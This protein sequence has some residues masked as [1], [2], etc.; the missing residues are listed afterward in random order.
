MAHR[1]SVILRHIVLWHHT[2][3]SQA[4]LLKGGCPL[5]LSFAHLLFLSS[6]ILYRSTALRVSLSR[7][8]NKCDGHW[9]YQ[10]CVQLRWEHRIVIG[11][12]LVDS[13]LMVITTQNSPPPPLSRHRSDIFSGAVHI[14]L[15]YEALTIFHT[16]G[17]VVGVGVE[18]MVLKFG[19]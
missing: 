16:A 15:P 8:N 14:K 13:L 2:I 10:Q 18:I 19:R 7:E 1:K 4:S 5:R 12:S 17:S 11:C 9:V 6:R 3:F